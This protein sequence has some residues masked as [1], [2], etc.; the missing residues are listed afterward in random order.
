M[1]TTKYNSFGKLAILAALCLS[2][3][4]MSS[5]R[6]RGASLLSKELSETKTYLEKE[7]GSLADA[8]ATREKEY[9][10]CV[11]ELYHRSETPRALRLVQA[12]R[13]TYPRRTQALLDQIE[14]DVS[15]FCRVCK[16]G[17]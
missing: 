5:D 12:V 11:S 7:C 8:H 15:R 4:A 2:M 3:E 14:E 6:H 13:D 9:L 16:K 10:Q 1:Q 17:K